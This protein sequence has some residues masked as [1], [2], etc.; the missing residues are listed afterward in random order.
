[1]V[2]KNNID[3]GVDWTGVSLSIGLFV[4]IVVAMF[5]L[6][7]LKKDGSK[8][9]AEP[10]QYAVDKLSEQDGEVVIANFNSPTRS[11]TYTS[12]ERE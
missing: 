6:I 7:I 11:I 12:Q 10:A 9:L 2:E 3:V 8:C 5:A 4:L 1:M